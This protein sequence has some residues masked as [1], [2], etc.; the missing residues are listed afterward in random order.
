MKK[1]L[2]VPFVAVLLLGIYIYSISSVHAYNWKQTS[3]GSAG[4]FLY[5]GEAS[6]Y[7]LCGPILYKD[8]ERKGIIILHISDRLII[9][10]FIDKEIGYYMSI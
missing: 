1:K 9:Y 6:S 3:G 2:I 5:F 4:D 10:S 7:R 8:K